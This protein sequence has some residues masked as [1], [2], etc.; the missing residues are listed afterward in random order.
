MSIGE[1]CNRDVVIVYRGENALEAAKL[2]RQCHV[3]DVVVVSGT[4]ISRRCTLRPGCCSANSCNSPASA[5]RRQ[6]ANTRQP[7]C[8]Y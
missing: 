7:D 1:F 3:G 8:A 5:G 6:V 2:M 4:V